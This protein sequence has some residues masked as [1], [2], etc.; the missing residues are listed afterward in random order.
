VIPELSLPKFESQIIYWK[1]N[2]DLLIKKINS[3]VIK[4]FI[5]EKKIYIGVLNNE[6]VF[7]VQH[8]IFGHLLIKLEI[9]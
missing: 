7:L 3:Q 9:K 4:S 6:Y 5:S 1:P 2:R 8:V